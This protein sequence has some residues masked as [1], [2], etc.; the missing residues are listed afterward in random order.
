M[1]YAGVTYVV[2]AHTLMAYIDVAVYGHVLYSYDPGREQRRRGG[3][4]HPPGMCTCTRAHIFWQS[5]SCACAC[6]SYG[7]YSYGSTVIACLVL[8]QCTY[9]LIIISIIIYY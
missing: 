9:I 2:V 5:C 8:A 1:A 4:A 6:S 3:R 7:V